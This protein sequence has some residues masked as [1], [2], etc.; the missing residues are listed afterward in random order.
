MTDGKIIPPHKKPPFPP[1]SARTDQNRAN[2]KQ[3]S[4]KT[5]PH[6]FERARSGPVWCITLLLF[7]IPGRQAGRQTHRQHIRKQ[8]KGNSLRKIRRKSHV[9]IPN[10]SNVFTCD[11]KRKETAL[12]SPFE[13]SFELFFWFLRGPGWS[14]SRTV[15]KRDEC[16]EMNIARRWILRHGE[17]GVGNLFW[18]FEWSPSAAQENLLNFKEWQDLKINNSF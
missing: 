1:V 11:L 9:G 14:H 5:H 2:T 12:P 16:S 6:S 3:N 18:V 10:G 13:L 15:L 17:R 4:A 7:F 8:S